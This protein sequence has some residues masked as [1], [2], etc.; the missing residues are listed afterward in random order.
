MKLNTNSHNRSFSKSVIITGAI[1]LFIQ[2]AALSCP[3]PQELPNPQLSLTGDTQ[4]YFNPVKLICD[5]PDCM[6]E[7][8]YE[9]VNGSV[10]YYTQVNGEWVYYSTVPGPYS[11]AYAAGPCIGG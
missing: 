6:Q 8:A 10:D 2:S 11:S 9:D 7:C 1:A 4:Y 3:S 5:G